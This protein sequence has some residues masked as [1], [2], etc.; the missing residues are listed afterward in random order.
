MDGENQNNPIPVGPEKIP[1][2]LYKEIYQ[3]VPIFCVDVIAVDGRERY[4]LTKRKNKPLKDTWGFPGGRV[5]KNE[6]VEDAA[7]RKL[8]EETG[9]VGKFIRQIGFYEFI[10][11]EGSYENTSV[12]TPVVVCLVRVSG[13]EDVRL[14]NQSSEYVWRENID[15]DLHLHLREML[16]R[17]GFKDSTR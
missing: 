11:K 8:H 6:K 9:L 14:D 16:V 13:K 3:S 17:A 4:L 5:L 2:T 7:M 12:H 15:R 1:D 10:D